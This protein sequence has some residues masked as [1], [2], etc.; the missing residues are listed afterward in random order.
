MDL[1]INEI[2]MEY[3]NLT[4]KQWSVEDRPREKML[5]SGIET[6]SDAEIIAILIGSGTRN[7]TALELAKKI[8]SI[9]GNN[10][11]ELGKLNITDLTRVKGMG[12]SKAISILAAI[13]LGR[14][15][16]FTEPQKKTQITSS[17]DVFKIF[18]P[19]LA[20]LS[21][22][23]FWVLLLNRSNR[24][25]DTIC[26]SKG[27]LSGTVIDTKIILNKALSKLASAIIICHNHPSG[28]IQPSE[29]DRIITRKIGSA[30]KTMD[31]NLLDHIIISGNGFYSFADEGEIT[32]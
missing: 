26:I 1:L 17:Q 13:E 19:K 12:E 31:I 29:A 30:A 15:R 10:L 3:K 22:E 6:L 23:E 20:D 5:K 25:I 28:N 18:E 8:L 32:R 2:Y 27:G 7:I 11:S 9:S 21:H 4:I 24:V 16:K 14:R